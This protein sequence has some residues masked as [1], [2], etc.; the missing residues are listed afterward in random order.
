MHP[1]Y[2]VSIC[3]EGDMKNIETCPL[4]LV[5][6]SSDMLACA[7]AS[8]VEIVDY[9]KEK[10][11]KLEA[12]AAANGNSGALRPGGAKTNRKRLRE[13]KRAK[14][15]EKKEKKL[16]RKEKNEKKRRKREKK[17]LKQ[18]A[19]EVERSRPPPTTHEREPHDIT[20]S[21]DIT[22]TRSDNG[23]HNR[24]NPPSKSRLEEGGKKRDIRGRTELDHDA[25][26]RERDE[27]RNHDH[28]HQKTR[29]PETK[30]GR[31]RHGGV[32][33]EVGGGKS[34]SGTRDDARDNHE[35]RSDCW[36][37]RPRDS[38]R[39]RSRSRSRSVRRGRAAESP[40][41]KYRRSRSRDRY[42]DRFPGR[43]SPSA[44]EAASSSIPRGQK[45][46]R[47][48][49]RNAPQG[50]GE[51][52]DSRGRGKEMRGGDQRQAARGSP[53]PGSSSSVAS[54][55]DGSSSSSTNH[56]RGGSSSSSSSSSLSRGH[57]TDRRS[58]HVGAD[59]GGDIKGIGQDFSRS[60][61]RDRRSNRDVRGWRED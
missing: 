21:N 15:N 1:R 56:S 42:Q 54:S 6:P 60:F 20:T 37:G 49:R 4:L 34:R 10:Q 39:N 52:R 31:H 58:R 41:S 51:R 48:E 46:M 55:S 43:T 40:V 24:Y 9:E 30:H 27:R 5:L 2:E 61:A 13:E 3:L 19:K 23:G 7:E 8:L 18:A 32:S 44:H 38:S 53:S 36:R 59:K 22:N 11:Q 14:K 47:A 17:R 45:G 26:H 12:L 50:G 28:A 33:D 29:S 16:A 35:Q 57:G 25:W